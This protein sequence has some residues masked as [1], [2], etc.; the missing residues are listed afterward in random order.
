M[1]TIEK[2]TSILEEYYTNS[3]IESNTSTWFKIA[4]KILENVDI[5]D[6]YIE[7]DSI[8]I[9]KLKFYRDKKLQ[10]NQKELLNTSWNHGNV[11]LN[12]SYKEKICT[13]VKMIV[14]NSMYPSLLIKLIDNGIITLKIKKYYTFFKF[15]VRNRVKFK[16]NLGSNYL[17]KYLINFFFG[18]L[19][20]EYSCVSTQHERIGC[21]NFE[22]FEIYKHLLYINIKNKLQ[23]DLIYLDTDEFF[24]IDNNY[25]FNF[26][27]PYEIKNLNSFIPF[28]KK[29]YIYF[30]NSQTYYR[31]FK[32]N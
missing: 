26:D 10:Y 4:D 20:Y 27:I 8:S 5:K 6:L 29:K 17:C 19:T 14:F 28:Q 3:K 11:Y 31:G 25:N 24:Y 1:T 13:N 16:N 2:I 30:E 32:L 7:D 18:I 15:I 22:N 21:R 12:D 23:N 9:L